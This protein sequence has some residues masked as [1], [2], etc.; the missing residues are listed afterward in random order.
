[1]TGDIRDVPSARARRQGDVRFRLASGAEAGG[2]LNA[3]N[4]HVAEPRPEEINESVD[5]TGVPRSLWRHLDD[6]PIDQLDSLVMPENASLGHPMVLV[7]GEA[8]RSWLV[9]LGRDGHARTALPTLDPARSLCPVYHRP[10]PRE[11]D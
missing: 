10:R 2:G 4:S 8:S 9:K 1:M 5:V 7:D 11:V 3:D 6:L